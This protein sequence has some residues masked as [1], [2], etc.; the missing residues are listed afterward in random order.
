MDDAINGT[1]K[2][3]CMRGQYKLIQ[4]ASLIDVSV[5]MS[6]ECRSNVG[7]VSFTVCGR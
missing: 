3:V 1:G 4:K 2:L 5:G 6:V 7:Q